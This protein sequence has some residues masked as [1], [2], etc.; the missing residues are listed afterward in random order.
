MTECWLWTGESE[1]C[2]C[3]HHVTEHCTNCYRN[4]RL[5]HCHKCNECTSF[6]PYRAK[7][8]TYVETKPLEVIK[9]N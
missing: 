2:K 7:P 6:I 3:T 4:T 9:T 5:F 8:G 1:F